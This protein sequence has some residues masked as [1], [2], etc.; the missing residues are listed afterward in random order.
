MSLTETYDS[1]QAVDYHYGQFPPS[2]LDAGR[3]LVPLSK[4]SAA[5]ARYDQMLKSLH[6]SA[7]LLGPLRNQEAVIS[8]RMEGT[9]STLDEVLRYEA[10]VD[11]V[12]GTPSHHRHDAMEVALYGRALLNAQQRIEQGA[13]LSSWLLRSAHAELLAFGRGATARPGE[14]KVDQNYLVDSAKRKILFQPIA[15]TYLQDG[16]DRLFQYIDAPDIEILIKTAVSHVEFEALH[17]FDD[18]NG[19]IGRMLITLLLWKFNAISAPHFYVSA[20]FERNRDEYIDRMRAVS[21]EGAWT[22]W[23]VF[24]LEGLENQAAENLDAAE[25]IRSLYE[26][27]KDQFRDLLSSQWATTALDFL[28][29]RPVFRNRAFTKASGIP[30]ATA[31][32]F[33]RILVDHGVLDTLDAASGRRSALYAFEPLL[34]IVRS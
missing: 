1:S 14:L 32:R 26:A 2:T 6:N 33:T 15:P 31:Q 21:S 10:E 17:P 4:A 7:I 9:V 22:D 8:S 12:G 18:G 27:M 25:R 3:L 30:T 19:R 16:I 34:K 20:Y 28:F 29:S 23:V 13:G 5:I 24:F 11:E